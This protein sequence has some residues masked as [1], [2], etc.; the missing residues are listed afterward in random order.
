MK[1]KINDVYS[2]DVFNRCGQ[3]EHNAIYNVQVL[4]KKRRF[5][6]KTIYIARCINTGQM[7][8]CTKNL[9]TPFPSNYSMGADR[10]YVRYPDDNPKITNEDIVSITL[11]MEQVSKNTDLYTYLYKLK[12]KLEYYYTARDV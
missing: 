6:R 9:L 7:I 11:A 8:T 2:F 4:K 1:I 12:Q 10:V 5:L 3:K